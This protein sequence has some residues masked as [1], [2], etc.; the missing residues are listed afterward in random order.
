MLA[1]NGYNYGGHLTFWSI[2]EGELAGIFNDQYTMVTRE[3][4]GRTDYVTTGTL[5]YTL[6]Q[7]IEHKKI[8]EIWRDIPFLG[9]KTKN[10]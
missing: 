2:T 3:W 4:D 5:Y 1:L 7:K 6:G 10:G 9:W 8:V